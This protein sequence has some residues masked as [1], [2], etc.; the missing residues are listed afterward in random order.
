MLG[1]SAA[2][3]QAIMIILTASLL[4]FAGWIGPLA[5]AAL[6]AVW[7]L[8]APVML[9]ALG[10]ADA[11]GIRVAASSG[12]NSINPSRFLVAI[13][14]GMMTLIMLLVLMGWSLIPSRL[15]AIFT[16][17]HALLKILVPLIPL[18]GCLLLF[19]SLSFVVLSAL[20]ALRDIAWPTG[21]EI[22]TMA[23]LVPVA[24]WLAFPMALGVRGLIMA[25]L[26]SAVLRTALLMWR[27]LWLT[28]SDAIPACA[29]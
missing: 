3:V 6:S 14:A 22:G 1:L 9:I 23:A 20:R 27:F 2:V 12:Q 18:A 5:L 13:S 7:T 16:G 25:A 15:A 11:T 17:D 29:V 8:N 28:K 10:V 26:A 24:I 19:D 21:I 4:V